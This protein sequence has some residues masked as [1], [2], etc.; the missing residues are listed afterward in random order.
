MQ[1]ARP[2][3][4]PPSP[5]AAAVQP[6]A[7][8]AASPSPATAALPA[9]TAAAQIPAI[10]AAQPPAAA[11]AQPP[12]PTAVQCAAAA[13]AAAKPLESADVI[14][15]SAAIAAQPAGA[16]HAPV[17]VSA[18]A[19]AATRSVAAT[20]NATAAATTGATAAATT[21]A[22]AAPTRGVKAA[23]SG[24]A[25][26]AAVRRAVAATALPLPAPRALAMITRSS[27]GASLNTDLSLY[28]TAMQSRL[29]LL[30]HG[31][32]SCK[33]DGNCGFNAASQLQY[34][35]SHPSCS[36]DDLT[37]VGQG[38]Q[39]DMRQLATDMLRTNISLQKALCHPE[40][41]TDVFNIWKD[42]VPARQA[43]PDAP[44]W[45]LL[46]DLVQKSAQSSKESCTLTAA[47]VQF[48]IAMLLG[49]RIYANGE[50][51]QALCN[52]SAALTLHT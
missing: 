41:E 8:A 40:V 11:A 39:Q 6:P 20:R 10:A 29:H 34:R 32:V 17:P 1:R 47:H 30:S 18:R 19:V 36:I 25:T 52:S 26:A 22:T 45:L 44:V 37:G 3:K 13:A 24:S 28:Q 5:A 15:P 43:R 14:L 27:G 4:H 50:Q 7:T 23:A 42:L 46:A 49:K 21:G 33:A 9:A 35:S 31:Y 12:S 38:Q 51:S 2:H 48:K 16:T